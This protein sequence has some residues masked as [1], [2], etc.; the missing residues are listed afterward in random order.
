MTHR[1]GTVLVVN[2]LVFCLLTN[3]I[4]FSHFPNSNFQ[5]LASHSVAEN[6]PLLC[7]H[8]HVVMA[9]SNFDLLHNKNKVA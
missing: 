1:V 2:N 8:S 5:Q 4:L 3:E 9:I 7:C 6:C